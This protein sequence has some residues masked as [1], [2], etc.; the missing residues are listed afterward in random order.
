MF[1]RNAGIY[2]LPSPLGVT[3]QKTNINRKDHTYEQDLILAKHLKTKIH[4]NIN[5]ILRLGLFCTS[6]KFGL[7]QQGENI[8]S[9][10]QNFGFRG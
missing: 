3:T 1:L 8:Q 5:I 4:K 6:V 7:V 2:L 10:T 9:G